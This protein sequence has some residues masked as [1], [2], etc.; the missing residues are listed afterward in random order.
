MSLRE[1]PESRWPE[2]LEQFSRS[3]RAWLATLDHFGPG[4]PPVDAGEYALRSVTPEESAGR[5]L[6]IE[7]RFQ[8]DAHAH[9]AVRIQAPT[10]VSVDETNEGT[11]R[12]LEILDEKGGCTRIRFRAAPLSEMLDGIAPGELSS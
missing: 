7:V 2:F 5:I 12:G 3:H 10:R 6:S 11:A 4:A 9:G 1:I 8:K